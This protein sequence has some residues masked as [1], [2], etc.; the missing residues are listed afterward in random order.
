[1][2]LGMTDFITKGFNPWILESYQGFQ[3]L[4]F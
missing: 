2:P 3:S 4:N 1:M